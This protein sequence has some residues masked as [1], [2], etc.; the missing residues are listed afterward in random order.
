MPHFLPTISP[1]V[2]HKSSLHAFNHPRCLFQGRMPHVRMGPFLWSTLTGPN[3]ETSKVCCD[4]LLV[5]CTM[6]LLVGYEIW[7]ITWE[8]P[9]CQMSYPA[10]LSHY[11]V[12]C[13]SSLNSHCMNCPAQVG[14]SAWLQSY[15]EKMKR[16]HT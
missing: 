7:M 16:G 2:R 4:E 13:H 14:E 8:P 10:K 11:K 12:V 1:R 3:A 15:L 9:N 5:Y 6:K